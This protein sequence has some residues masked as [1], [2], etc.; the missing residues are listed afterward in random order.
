MSSKQDT[1]DIQVMLEDEWPK[2]HEALWANYGATR[3][4]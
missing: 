3:N 2:Y 4:V 1:A